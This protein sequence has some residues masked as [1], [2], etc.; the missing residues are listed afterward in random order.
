MSKNKLLLII[1][2]GIGIRESKEF[3]SL[4][5][6]NTPNLHNFFKS[7]PWTTLACHGR[8]VGL[9]DGIMGNSEVG[10]LN[11]GAGRVVMQDLVRIHVSFED[12]SFEKIPEF[13]DLIDYATKKQKAVHLMGLLSDAGVHSDYNHAM[14]IM[15]LLKD[16][17]VEKIYLHAIT[18]GRD[19]PPNSG[20]NY[21]K[22]MLAFMNEH[23]C[24][25]LASVIGRY[26]IMDR[27]KRW[28]RVQRAYEA[29]LNGTGVHT[30]D[31]LAAMQQMYDNDIT[32][33]FITPILVRNDSELATLQDGDA[34][35]TFNFRADRMREIAMALNDDEF[36]GFTRDRRVSLKYVTMTKYQE[37]F[38]YPVL[39][40]DQVLEDIFGEVISKQSLTQLR[41]AETEKY[42]HVTYFFNGGEEKK[43]EGE[44]RILV[45][46]PKVATYDMQPEMSAPEVTRRLLDAIDQDKYDVIILNYANGDMVGHTGVFEAAIKAVEEVD[47]DVGLVV[48]KFTGKGGTV[49]ITADHG[50]SEEMWDTANNQPHTQHTLNPVPFI[51]LTPDNRH[52]RLRS[53]G[54]LCD[55]APTMLQLMNIPKPD[56]MTGKSLII[57]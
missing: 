1:M 54:K 38:P 49:I 31:P 23:R 2:D 46:S 4:E 29:L 10:H 45:P 26:Y 18:D 6:S 33:E 20:I 48:D 42:A 21:L 14:Q 25:T 3:N 17:G 41:I 44:D 12:K 13:V 39:F 57:E 55:I 40:K 51:L 27:D 8:A 36:D 34:V 50:N 9:P 56:K 22:N 11:I 28:D 43:F 5:N 52:F 53:D 32:D 16:R 47:K 35:L 24:G 37:S 7:K 30:D 15:K 19:T